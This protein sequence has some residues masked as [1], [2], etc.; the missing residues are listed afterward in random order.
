MDDH[1]S[2]LLRENLEIVLEDSRVC[3]YRL[4]QIANHF[5]VPGCFRMCMQ[6]VKSYA[7]ESCWV[8][9]AKMKWR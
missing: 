4:L 2:S 3:I 8:L 5:S 9:K 6:F 7:S 1:I